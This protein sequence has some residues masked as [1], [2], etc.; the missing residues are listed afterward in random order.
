MNTR[1][2]TA[3]AAAVLA[4]Q[5]AVAAG[6]G[7]GSDVVIRRVPNGGIKASAAVDRTGTLH[8]IYYTGDPAH[9]DVMYVTSGDGGAT[10]SPPLR[11]N[12]QPSSAMGASSA[13]G[14]HLALGKNGRVH[15][16]WMGS[17]KATPRGPLNPAMPADSPYNGTPLLYSQLDPVAKAFTPQRNLMTTTIALDGDSSIASDEAGRVYVV[18]HGQ[19]PGG[20]G[21]KDRGVWVA[22]SKDDGATFGP[23][24]NAITGSTG[25]CACCGL[26]AQAD[27]KGSVAIL[28]RAATENIHRG[29]RL[30]LSKDQGEYFT[31]TQLDEWKIESCPMS[32]A[33]LALTPSGFV[34]AWENNA[35]LALARSFSTAPDTLAGDASR[36][37]PSLAFNSKGESLLAWVEGISFGQGGGVG[38]QRFD[39]DD[40]P[41]GPVGHGAG[42]PGHGNVAA[43]A[44][45]DGTFAV[46][47]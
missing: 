14:P 16:I 30:L 41:A 36:K 45:A 42:L 12:S 25:V 34:G 33:A 21:E 5:F 3:I 8:L 24:Q 29:M 17:S 2:A 28:Y 27:A 32:T 43:V 22:R 1:L 47:Y 44:L 31:N 9:G 13:R 46:I 23:E 15:S 20:K 39:R 10:F 35:R 19:V 40:K 6:A 26:T 18:W 37:H 11:V 4:G 7:V 38:W